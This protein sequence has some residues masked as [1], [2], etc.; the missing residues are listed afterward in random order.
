MKRWT[1]PIAP[2]LG[3][4]LLMAGPVLGI[5]CPGDCDGSGTVTVDEIVTLINAVFDDTALPGCAA[6]DSNNDGH[7]TVDEVVTA[8]HF[9]LTGCPVDAV[10]AAGAAHAV[11]RALANVPSLEL[12]VS[13]G[14][15][16]AGGPDRCGIAG[17]YQS[18]CLDSEA[19]VIRI[20]IS[21]TDCV[22]PTTEG[23]T[24][25]A[26]SMTLTALGL[27]PSV[28]L[29][30]NLRFDFAL[31]ARSAYQNGQ[32]AFT[33]DV[34]STI[35]V[36]G[37]A[38]GTPPCRT[39]GAGALLSGPVT[40]RL[41]GGGAL[42]IDM[43]G[44]QAAVSLEEFQIVP[45]CDP[46]RITAA[47]NGHVRITDTL[48][49]PLVTVDATLDNLTITW[50]RVTRTIEVSGTVASPAFGG[51]ATITTVTPLAFPLD[52]PCFA[53]GAVSI[54]TPVAR[55]GLQYTADGGLQVDDGGDHVPIQFASCL[56]R[57]LRG[58]GQ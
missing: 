28:V 14:F 7:I 33:S 52:Q 49:D 53:G 30:S 42:H 36:N 50:D 3:G 27:C 24:A 39:R 58:S 6:A 51:V 54:A 43:T 25:L 15:S 11:V 13:A 48:A 4:L 2:V 45:T 32:P 41:P 22:L 37:F 29:P 19:D 23:S 46:G 1:T 21:T 56:A 57:G 38:F 31:T 9:A 40:Y 17:Q 34:G 47:L 26:G 18:Q 12:L 10:S 8:V 44:L 55:L 20:A 16:F 5:P 35:T